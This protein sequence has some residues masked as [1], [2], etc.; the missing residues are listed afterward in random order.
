MTQ[1]KRPPVRLLVLATLLA[2]VVAAMIAFRGSG[3]S[4]VQ[5]ELAAIRAAGLPTSAADLDRWYERPAPSNNAALLVAEAA[6]DHVSVGGI[7]TAF[8]AAG[9]ALSPEMEKAIA[10]HI[11]ENRE[12]IEK[13]HEAARL[14]G[15]RYPINLNMGQNTLLPHLAHVKGMTQTLRYEAILHA[16]NNDVERAVHSVDTSFALAR[17]LRNEPLLISELVRIACVAITLQEVERLL[18]DQKLDAGELAALDRRLIEAEED[19]RRGIVRAMAGERALAIDYFL[20]SWPG[21]PPSNPNAA[22]SMAFGALRITGLRDRDLRLYLET[23]REFVAVATNDFGEMLTAADVAEQNLIERTSHGLGQLAIMTRMI[24]P[25][26]TK[27][28]SKEVALTTRLRAAR[29]AIAVE[30]YRVAHNGA[31]PERLEGLEGLPNPLVD[32]VFGKRFEFEVSPTNRFRVVGTEPTNVFSS[33]IVYQIYSP[34]A[35]QKLSN[36]LANAFVVRR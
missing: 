22:Q 3:Q 35:A 8:P 1:Q 13:L 23:T 32:P 12:V 26:I 7:L 15:S 18:S 21:V 5:R 17:T 10:Q 24:V 29:M 20:T 14:E 25:S 9:E 2:I 33:A 27:A 28:F 19:G 36:G 34:G 16:A 30:R 4:G 6:A 11:D 31:L